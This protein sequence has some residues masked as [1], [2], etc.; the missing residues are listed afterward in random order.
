MDELKYSSI[1]SFLLVTI[2][3]FARVVMLTFGAIMIITTAENIKNIHVTSW[4]VNVS[5]L[6]PNLPVINPSDNSAIKMQ[7]AVAH[8]STHPR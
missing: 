8:A 5:L 4:R 7:D 2:E 1:P 6:T 3:Q